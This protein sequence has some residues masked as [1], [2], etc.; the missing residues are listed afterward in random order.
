MKNLLWI[1]LTILFLTGCQ[2]SVPV[3][4]LKAS[5]IDMSRMRNVA[6]L[7][8]SVPAPGEENAKGDELLLLQINRV[9]QN[10][11]FKNA[12]QEAVALYATDQFVNLLAN[13]NYFKISGPDTVREALL[14]NKDTNPGRRELAEILGVDAFIIPSITYM[15]I[16]IEE[17]DQISKDN[18][19]KQQINMFFTKDAALKIRFEIINAVQGN[20]MV[21]PELRGY[22]F[23]STGEYLKLPSN[24]VM[25]RE[26]IDRILRSVPE[27]LVPHKVTIYRSLLA[28]ETKN[29]KMQELDKLVREKSY[30]AALTGYLSIWRET[31]NPA[32]GYNAAILLEVTQDLD[33]A[34]ALMIEVATT[35]KLPRALEELELLKKTKQ[36]AAAAL[37]EK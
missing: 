21:I 11:R 18:H 9:L 20:S 26:I 12:E 16:N 4:V 24:Q 5:E 14:K 1:T 30:A 2:T 27:K 22:K 17:T 37:Q 28:D 8:F 19:G 23:E 6:V 13:T 36:E 35:T 25:Y 34:I 31:K 32:A 7:E 15:N 33:G 29:L 3:D 10:T